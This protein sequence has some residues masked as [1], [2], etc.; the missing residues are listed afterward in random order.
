MSAKIKLKDGPLRARNKYLG[1]IDVFPTPN[2]G[3]F[4][5][6][7]KTIIHADYLD[8]SEMSEYDNG[9][10]TMLDIFLSLALRNKKEGRK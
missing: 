2:K 9:I 10:I 3:Y 7:F 8:F 1:V 4:I 5:I 6:P